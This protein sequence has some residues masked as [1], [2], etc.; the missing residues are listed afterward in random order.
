MKV[1]LA[2]FALVFLAGCQST[3]E[4]E[5]ALRASLARTCAGLDRI[6][7]HYDGI[8]IS[9]LISERTMSRVDAVR[10]QSS[11]ICTSP[12]TATTESLTASA[13]AAYVALYAAFKESGDRAG[14]VGLENLRK[15][16]KKEIA[17][18]HYH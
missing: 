7:A 4:S 2:I 6:F 12:E 1:I 14:F 10:Q 17:D 5:A 9:G 3:P 15:S 16:V 13:A 18:V 11:R 8:A